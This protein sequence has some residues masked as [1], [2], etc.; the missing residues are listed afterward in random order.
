MGDR[1]STDTSSPQLHRSFLRSRSQPKPRRD[2][3]SRYAHMMESINPKSEFA[4]SS[5]SGSATARRTRSSSIATSPLLTNPTTPYRDS[6]HGRLGTE[7]SIL[8]PMMSKNQASQ[9]PFPKILTLPSW[10]QDTIT[11]LDSSHPLCAVFPALHCAPEPDVVLHPSG[12]P[13]DDPTS[14]RGVNWSSPFLSLPSRDS[15]RARLPDSDTSDEPQKSLMHRP[16][17]HNDS[18]LPLR[19]ESPAPPIGGI[20]HTEI[21][22]PTTSDSWTSSSVPTKATRDPHIC[23]FENPPSPASPSNRNPHDPCSP[24]RH[25]AECDV[26]RYDPS[27]TDLTTALSPSEPFVFEKPTRVYFDSPI[28]DPIS[29]DPLE[30]G[31]YDPFKLDP[32]EYKNLGFKWAPFVPRTG[33]RES[34]M[35]VSETNSHESTDSQGDLRCR[36]G[37]STER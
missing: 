11:K 18:L 13:P 32:E 10:L 21:A 34:S 2:L 3:R 37:E 23:G 20:S 35:G 27:Q 28:E 15:S 6:G 5:D 33:M 1:S 4:G 14:Q 29:S 30:P 36:S 25:D 9:A 8:K 12:D 16:L 31:D 26:F 24:A 17:Y 22:F 19:S 7:F